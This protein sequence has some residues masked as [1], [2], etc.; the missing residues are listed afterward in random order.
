MHKAKAIV[1]GLLF[2]GTLIFVPSAKGQA[3]SYKRTNVSSDTQGSANFRSAD[4]I[5]AWSM[6][7]I[8]G[9][10]TG[11]V[12]NT[13]DGFKVEGL[14]S[15]FIEATEDGTISVLH[16]T[17]PIAIRAVDHS[18]MGAVY[19]GLALVTESGGA[20]ILLAA[21]FRSGII[22]AFDSNFAPFHL[23]GTFQD[24]A[25]PEGFAPLGIHVIA[26]NRVVVTFAQQN[27]S[28]HDPVTASGAGFVSLFDFEGNFLHRIAS[29]G[30]LNAPMGAAIAPATFGS[31][32]SAL[33]VGNFGDGTINAFDMHSQTFL[34]Q[35][36]D[37]NGRVL[38]TPS[39][40][41]L[42]VAPKVHPNTLFLTA[43][44]NSARHSMFAEVTPDTT[45]SPAFSLAAAP[46]SITVTQGSS[47]TVTITATALNGFNGMINSFACSGEPGGASCVFSKTSLM[48][49]GSTTDSL[50]LTLTTSRPTPYGTMMG[51]VLPLSSMGMFGLVM[52]RSRRRKKLAHRAWW[53]WLGYAGAMAILCGALLSVSGCGGYGHH[54]TTGGTPMGSHTVTVSAASG[55]EMESTT[56]SLSVQ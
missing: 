39:L 26:D 28:K 15:D 31:F 27:S 40:R 12:A 22:E 9:M 30:T 7:H 49:V 50:T 45:T 51:M 2:F 33:L 43:L 35:L 41:E 53:R 1:L 54:G 14:R 11:V 37:S 46:A 29:G 42:F 5:N 16:S 10:P 32:A 6:A 4:L 25:A 24:P 44:D 23:Q 56:F 55:T 38:I 20:Q 13:G 17:S 18:K 3:N 48:P 19:K 36:K 8:P 52:V 47:G 34:G 21:N